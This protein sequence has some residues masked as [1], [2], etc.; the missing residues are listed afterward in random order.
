M[1][2]KGTYC[3]Y[4][5][6]LVSLL[7][8]SAAQ[9]AFGDDS[10][11]QLRPLPL[12]EVQRWFAQTGRTDATLGQPSRLEI[13]Q[14]QVML[15][16]KGLYSG[17]PDGDCGPKTAKALRA[18]QKQSGL[19]VTGKL[20]AETYVSLNVLPCIWIG[21]NLKCSHPECSAA[22]ILTQ[23]GLQGHRVSCPSI[24]SFFIPTSQNLLKMF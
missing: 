16:N 14:A 24:E 1:K 15:T 23:N 8:L 20:D 10:Q 3:I 22:M 2:T 5:A 18:Y 13:V 21:S 9:G 11:L 17:K 6:A 4:A 19:A 12:G 7:F